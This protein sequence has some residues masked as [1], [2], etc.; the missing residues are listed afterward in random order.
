MRTALFLFRRDLRVVD[1]TSLLAAIRDGYRILGAF[2]FPPEQILPDKN[3]YFSNAAVQFMCESLE[4]LSREL[5][6]K[7]AFLHTDHIDA[8]ERIYASHPFDAVYFNE[9]YSVYARKRDATIQA[10][11]K[12]RDIPCV[13]HEDYGLLP[14]MDG[15]LDAAEHRPYKVLAQFYKRVQKD[16]EIRRPDTTQ[17]KA[18]F[19][20]IRH[21]PAK[22]L[23]R[24][25]EI[26]KFYVAN[27]QAALHGGRTAAK[28][29][30]ALLGDLKDYKV[31]RDF[32]AKQKTTL[33]SP[34]LKFGC[35]S[36]REVYWAIA[37]TLGKEHA[38][39]RE[40]VFR[41]FYLKIY[42]LI[43][44]LQRGT[45]LHDALDRSIPW[46]YDTKVFR[47]WTEGRTGFPI[48]DA[49]MRELN[50]TGHQHNRIRMI[51]SSVLTKYFLIDWRWGLKYYY[52][53]LV[54]ADIFSNTAGWG[55][56]S[57]TGPDAV[58]YFRAPFNPFIQSKEF[59]PDAEYI[60]RWLPEL[61]DVSVANI[62]KWFDAGVRAKAASTYP[63]PIM[64][65]KEASARAISV[66][67][68][69]FIQ[70]KK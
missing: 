51:C 40:L 49:G 60:K 23:L 33:L 21:P 58:P 42:A 4:D 14:L 29:R 34:Y 28:K 39:I 64:D 47:A 56:S 54:D 36:V 57:S 27:P 20:A 70:S 61:A 44:G 50:A 43:P 25:A 30:L 11:C 5:D 48:V 32:P 8:L 13:T 15:L 53:H 41:D 1:N 55:F 69:A 9:D 63:A 7:L 2:V 26:H 66:F 3:P 35:V 52:T 10:W 62:H 16:H 46:S 67:K 37:E 12:K 31:A 65:Y 18:A 59:D 38:L 17:V 19:V 6:H 68:S 24:I 45:A 22:S